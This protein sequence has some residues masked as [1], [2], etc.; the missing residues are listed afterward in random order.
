MK[1]SSVILH[2]AETAGKNAELLLAPNLDDA[3]FLIV[4]ESK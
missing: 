4:A 2:P 1:F 3:S